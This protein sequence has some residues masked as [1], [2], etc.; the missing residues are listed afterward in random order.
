MRENAETKGRRYLLEGRLLVTFVDPRRVRARC[1]G[2]GSV[3]RLGY[4][5]GAWYCSC[6]ARGVC[7]HLVALQ[8]VTAPEEGE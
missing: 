3:H 6:P 5:R 1:R 4:D 7:S 8:L 2:S